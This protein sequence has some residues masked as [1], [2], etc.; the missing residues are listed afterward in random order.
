MRI[1]QIM[2][3]IKDYYIS[4][5]YIE[6]EELVIPNNLEGSLDELVEYFEEN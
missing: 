5:K 3:D 6:D 1:E 4:A 2:V